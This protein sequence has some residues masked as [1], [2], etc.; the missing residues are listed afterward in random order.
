MSIMQK[1]KG[2][3]FRL[4]C[5]NYFNVPGLQ[6]GNREAISWRMVAKWNVHFPRWS[7]GRRIL[8]DVLSDY[9]LSVRKEK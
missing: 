2:D 5:F 9:L 3:G 4:S 1:V 6:D 7:A 8:T